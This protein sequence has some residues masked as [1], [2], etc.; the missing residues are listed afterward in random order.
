MIEFVCQRNH[1]I[2]DRLQSSPVQKDWRRVNILHVGIE[3]LGVRLEAEGALF[4]L[5]VGV[6]ARKGK[7]FRIDRDLF[8]VPAAH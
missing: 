8:F 1:Y 5:I 4:V 6:V 2:T 3:N 7:Y